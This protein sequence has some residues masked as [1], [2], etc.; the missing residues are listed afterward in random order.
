MRDNPPQKPFYILISFFMKR[1]MTEI[2]DF[3]RPILRGKL[4]NGRD[5]Y[6]TRNYTFCGFRSFVY[7]EVV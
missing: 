5:I 2:R 7:C 1:G 3:V 4:A 6:S